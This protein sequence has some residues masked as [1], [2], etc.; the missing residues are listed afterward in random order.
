MEVKK[1]QDL[2]KEVETYKQ[3]IEDAKDALASVEMELDETL[4][5]EFRSGNG[6]ESEEDRAAGQRLPRLSPKEEAEEKV[7][8]YI[9]GCVAVIVSTVALEDWRL[10]ERYAPKKLTVVDEDGNTVF[11]VRTDC[12]GGRC[13]H[14]EL[15]WGE[16][17][18]ENGKATITIL[19]DTDI[20][21]KREAVMDI[22][23]SAILD[24]IEIEKEMPN[25]V[26]EIHE[27]QEKIESCI[28]SL[29]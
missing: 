15:V 27:A 3:A 21:N 12:G 14:D 1:I 6:S 19:L 25:F 18:D 23:G 24:L 10:V 13:T 11:T 29:D 4:D 5:D 20:D 26:K 22:C 17:A 8:V 2:M 28:I 16:A 9:V 7:K